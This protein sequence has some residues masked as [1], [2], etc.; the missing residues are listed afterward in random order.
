MTKK[1]LFHKTIDK[2]FEIHYKLYPF[3]THIDIFH[4]IYIMV[5]Y[6]HPV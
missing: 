2:Q 5:K 6:E 4:T 1:I 3:L